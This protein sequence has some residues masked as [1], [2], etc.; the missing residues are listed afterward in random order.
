[1]PLVA[2]GGLLLLLGQSP[3]L[4]AGTRVRTLAQAG[5]A[6]V[7]RVSFD[8]IGG[9]GAAKRELR[10]ALEFLLH[11]DEVRAMGIRP[12][13]GIL[14]TGPPGTGKTL[15][16]RAAAGYT[17]SVF[18]SASGSE[19]VEMYAG[20]GASRVRD[21]FRRAREMA[22]Q[23][24][25]SSAII[26]I[27][28]LEVLGGRRGAHTSHLEYDQTLNQL[29]V[30]MDGIRTDAGVQVLVVGATNR[31]DLLDP[32]L[33]RPGRFD[34]VVQVDLPDRE[35]RLEI[36][37]LHARNKPLA[38]DADLEALAG[39]TFGF[40]GAQLE[41]LLNEAAILAFREGERAIRQRHL[42]EAVDKVILG[43][44]A[45]RR[46]SPGEKRRVAVH[47]AG[48]ALVGE[49]VSPGSVAAVTITPRGRAMGYVRS[50]PPQDHHLYTR[51][52]LEG[53]IRVALAGAVAEELL[54]GSRSTGAAS[55]F[56]QAVALARH[57]VESGLSELGVVDRDQPDTPRHREAV[58]AILREQEAAVREYLSGRRDAL[59]QVAAALAD[60]ESI[61]GEE[62]RALIAPG[63]DLCH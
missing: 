50:F 62:L 46:P 4:R 6:G 14:L 32:A 9:Q 22:R 1:M 48:H 61:T 11:R 27:D 8:D 58:A 31:P 20:V 41:S 56:D 26:F 29:L 10:E 12:L 25:R 42:V 52:M 47:E 60:R 5:A 40:S 17:G 2:V 39:Q 55:D 21:L 28:E 43:E 34:R 13:K 53:Q 36:L 51:G 45:D 35:G 15:L 49:W 16:A 37:R 44:R 7:P 3:G 18:L 19:F 54:C 63:P 33:T 24:G 30:E 38:P 57:I 59:E 23:A